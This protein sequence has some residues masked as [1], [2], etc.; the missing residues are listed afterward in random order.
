MRTKQF[1]NTLKITQLIVI[2]KFQY[3]NNDNQNQDD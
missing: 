1:T 2:A 3:S